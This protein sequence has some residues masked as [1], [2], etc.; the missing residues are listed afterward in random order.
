M[1]P[2]KRLRHGQVPPHQRSLLNSGVDSMSWDIQLT[3]DALRHFA[4]VFPRP[5]TPCAA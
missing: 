5:L 3:R 4:E 2:H 1:E